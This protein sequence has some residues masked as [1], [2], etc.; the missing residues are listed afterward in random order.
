MVYCTCKEKEVI[1]KGD[2]MFVAYESYCPK[3]GYFSSCYLCEEGTCTTELC[4]KHR[5]IMN[6]GLL[7][8][9]KDNL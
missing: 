3:H 7:E 9:K 1:E 4:A 5:R 2:A 6:N 8:W